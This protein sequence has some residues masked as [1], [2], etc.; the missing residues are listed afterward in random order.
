M[1]LSCIFIHQVY[2]RYFTADTKHIGST[3]RDLESMLKNIQLLLCLY[4]LA[5]KKSIVK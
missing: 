2:I 4:D 3:Y 5:K 1:I